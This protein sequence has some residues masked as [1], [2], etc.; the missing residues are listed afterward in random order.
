MIIAGAMMLGLGIGMAMG[1][2][3][4]GVL[5]GLGVGLLVQGVAAQLGKPITF[6][7]KKSDEKTPD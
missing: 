4:P 2:A 7:S 5:V 6:G 3:G 1:D